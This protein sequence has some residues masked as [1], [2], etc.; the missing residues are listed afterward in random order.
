LSGEIRLGIGI[1]G[2]GVQVT[3]KIMT[4]KC[5]LSDEPGKREKTYP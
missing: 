4:P 2:S 5:H 3:S 1:G